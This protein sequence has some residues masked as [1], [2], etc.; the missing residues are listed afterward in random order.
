METFEIKEGVLEYLSDIPPY[1]ISEVNGKV[2]F[3]EITFFPASGM[4]PFNPKDC[5]Y[6]LGS[7]IEL[8][9][10]QNI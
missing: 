1:E 6:M 3:G 10:K 2:Y 7:W 5:D 9:N 8:P 4:A